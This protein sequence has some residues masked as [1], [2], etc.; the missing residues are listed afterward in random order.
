M[1]SRNSLCSVMFLTLCG[2]GPVEAGAPV[3]LKSL[4]AT[5]PEIEVTYIDMSDHSYEITYH[6]VDHTIRGFEI[7]PP[8]KHDAGERVMTRRRIEKATAVDAA[9]AGRLDAL[10]EASTV[11]IRTDAEIEQAR[12]A[13]GPQPTCQPGGGIRI[14]DTY[15]GPT[16]VESHQLISSTPWDGAILE[17]FRAL[18]PPSGPVRWVGDH[19]EPVK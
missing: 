17:A 9:T 8:E 19:Y 14:G 7:V 4:T 6:V 11:Q 12:E 18:A 5:S 16:P 2:L 10:L 13:A 1:S 15:L 3:P